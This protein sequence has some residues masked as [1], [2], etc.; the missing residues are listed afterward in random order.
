MNVSRNNR[1]RRTETMIRR[2]TFLSLVMVF[3]SACAPAAAPTYIP[4]PT[5]TAVHTDTSTPTMPEPT[6]TEVPAAIAVSFT[7]NGRTVHGLL[8][9]K[10]AYGVVLSHGAAYDAA[11]W[12][13]Q[14]A[15]IARNGMVALSLEEV[16]PDDIIAANFYLCEKHGV[17]GVA[18]IGASA[19]GSTAIT[20]MSQTPLK[21]DQIILLS[22]IGDVSGLGSAPKL[23]VASEDEGISDAVRR[24]ANEAQGKQNEAL[25]FNGSAHA[26]AIFHTPNGPRLTSAI[27]ERLIERAQLIK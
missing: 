25:I 3:L 17:K 18:L 4:A 14:A 16:E 23:L 26:Q 6:P 24:M 10:G 2:F 13:P 9:G 7:H 1:Q 27:L 15:D 20:A 12:A 22:S 11:S 19:G 21:W 8:W 5:A